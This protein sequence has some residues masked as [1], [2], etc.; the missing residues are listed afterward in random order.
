MFGT[1]FNDI[2]ISRKNN[3]GDVV[4]RMKV[5]IHYAPMQKILARVEQDPNLNAPA[6]TLPRMSFEIVNMTFSPERKLPSLNRNTRVSG[7][8]ADINLSQYV[9]A[10][11]DIEF[12]LNIMTKNT[13]DGTKILEQILPFFKPD[14][15]VSVKL[16]DELDLYIDVPVILNSVTMDDSYEGDFLARRVLSWTLGFTVRGY[17]FGPVSSKKVIKFAEANVLT[18]VDADSVVGTVTARPGLTSDGEPT[19]ILTGIRASATTSVSNGGVSSIDLVQGG[20]GYGYEAATAVISPPS[21]SRAF[22]T[23]QVQNEQISYFDITDGGGYYSAIPT[24][25]LSSPTLPALTAVAVAYANFSQNEP[26]ANPVNEIQGF[27]L[28][29]DALNKGRYYTVPPSVTIAPPPASITAQATAT[30][31]ANNDIRYLSLIDL[32]NAGTNYE[33]SP[34]ATVTYNTLADPYVFVGTNIEYNGYYRFGFD[35][36]KIVGNIPLIPGPDVPAF[37]WTAN[38]GFYVYLKAK[39][40]EL[41]ETPSDWRDAGELVVIKR[42]ENEYPGTISLGIDRLSGG[43]ERLWVKVFDNEGNLVPYDTDYPQYTFS[44]ALASIAR[45]NWGPAWFRYNYASAT[46]LDISFGMLEP[47]YA[48]RA[49]TIYSYQNPELFEYLKWGA[50]VQPEILPGKP[51]YIT[52]PYVISWTGSGTFP[53]AG[54][55]ETAPISNQSATYWWHDWNPD[56]IENNFTLS[57][58]TN[59]WSLTDI[60]SFT[61]I[62]DVV[63]ASVVFDAPTPARAAQASAVVSQG[64]I[65]SFNLT[66]PGFGYLF[67]D[68]FYYNGNQIP[69]HGQVAEMT[70]GAP[71]GTPNQFTAVVT[72]VIANG[73]LVNIEIENG[74]IGYSPGANPTIT[75]A[76]PE[77]RTAT[78]QVNVN[79]QLKEVESFT[80]T[81]SGTGYKLP[82]SIVISEPDEVSIPKEDIFESDN[83]GFIVSIEEQ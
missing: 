43:T 11:Y 48:A 9:P 26:V 82:A 58:T 81:D 52:S 13:E 15:T 40:P 72:P 21:V 64:Q 30:I 8:D 80:V 24:Y 68:S 61:P 35:M 75:F 7:S 73:E 39:N 34:T 32:Q 31:S 18:G 63:S 51:F 83:W 6:M 28:T 19:S 3:V 46:E 70:I 78:A 50:S 55:Q 59:R 44:K 22:A 16:V 12:Q 29:W 57:T 65:Q 38:K 5:P 45:Y 66:D 76:L 71:T 14:I 49:L 79:Q 17:Y 56:L 53:I 47:R 67:E 69:G 23:P 20:S 10:P 37:S 33:T 36:D 42:N 25:T 77:A 62:P 41:A 1:L 74:G 54:P 2:V 27:S 4:Q 60:Q